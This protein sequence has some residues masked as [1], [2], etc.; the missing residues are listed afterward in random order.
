MIFLTINKTNK[1]VCT[2]DLFIKK[3]S[4]AFAKE[5]KGS[6]FDTSPRQLR[7]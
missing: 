7:A 1:H 5:S 4:R 3:A 6:G 2:K